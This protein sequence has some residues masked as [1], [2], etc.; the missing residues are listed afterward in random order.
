MF[1][2]NVD[3]SEIPYTTRSQLETVASHLGVVIAAPILI[4]ATAKFVPSLDFNW[5]VL[6]GLY[7]AL[8][9]NVLLVSFLAHRAVTDGDSFDRPTAGIDPRRR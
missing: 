8:L 6:A 1:A 4:W 2:D 9:V 3:Y 7:A 5:P